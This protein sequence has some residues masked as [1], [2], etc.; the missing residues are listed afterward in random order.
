M[1]AIVV[2]KTGGPEVLV[3]ADKE[4]PEPK[5][6]EA[7]IK[8]EAIG[9]NYIDI[10]HRTGLYPLPLSFT[11]GMEAAGVV[12]EIAQDVTNVAV[13]DRVAYAMN[14]GPYA[15][16]HAVPAIKLVRI[17][18]ELSTRDAAAAMLQGMTAHYLTTSTYVLKEGDWAIV[19][20]AA[21]GVGLLL[22]QMAKRVGAHV[23]GTVSTEAKAELAS[24]AGA[25]EIVYY[26]KQDFEAEAR[27]ITNGRGVEVVYD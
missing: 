25:D 10:Y 15:E 6:G 11:P 17:P 18:D 8:I 3:Y 13:G 26:N 4:R 21:G 23:I 2:E 9:L 12:E 16:Y 14:V 5:A 24:A 20:A 19:H 27:R 7:L 1:K 22:I